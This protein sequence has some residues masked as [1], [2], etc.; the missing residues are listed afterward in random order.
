MRKAPILLGAVLIVVG[1]IAYE[2][3][4]IPV[5]NRT[6]VSGESVTIRAGSSVP[7]AFPFPD[8]AL[9]TGTISSVSGGGSGHDD[10][11]FYVFDKNN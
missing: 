9:V 10:I 1:I 8:D 4:L 5:S 7:R 6:L 11:D 2:V 3:L